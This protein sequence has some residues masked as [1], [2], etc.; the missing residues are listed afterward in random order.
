MKNLLMAEEKQKYEKLWG[1][2]PEYR[3][4][5][6]AD[7]LTEV[8]LKHYHAQIL[9]GDRVI[10]F[11]CGAGRSAIDLLD[12]TLRADLVDFAENCLDDEIFLET[13][14][15]NPGAKFWECCLW[16][17]PSELRPA[18]WGICF[19]VLEH[20]P[21][22]QVDSVLTNLASKVTQ[23]LLVAID[24][25]ED[26]FGETV[27]ETLHLTVKPASWWETQILAHFR[28]EKKLLDSKEKIVWALAPL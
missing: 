8:F 7:T 24:L 1:T 27:G 6:A 13:V 28:I 21:T 23:G 19:D 16:D 11:G 18:K 5:S 3:D 10:D 12:A 9:T 14:G 22:Y 20:I 2:I 4:T 17:L 26:Q 25:Q 15:R